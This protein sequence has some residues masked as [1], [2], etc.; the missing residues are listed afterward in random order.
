MW[1]CILPII[2]ILRW[3]TLNISLQRMWHHYTVSLMMQK[4][5]RSR[6]DKGSISR[7]GRI[8]I[9]KHLRSLSTLSDVSFLLAVLRNMKYGTGVSWT[10][11]AAFHGAQAATNASWV[12]KARHPLD[13]ENNA[14]IVECAS[15][16]V[17]GTVGVHQ[18][19]IS[20]TSCKTHPTNGLISISSRKR[21]QLWTVGKISTRN[22][23]RLRGAYPS[24]ASGRLVL[25]LVNRL[26]LLLAINPHMNK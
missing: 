8:P 22:W 25:H 7:Y 13:D 12:R 3:C 4:L 19:P 24:I 16:E 11:F 26:C 15:V 6:T 10:K 17:T 14:S 20:C 21:E 1:Q 5:A 9:D 23:G 2:K 18:P